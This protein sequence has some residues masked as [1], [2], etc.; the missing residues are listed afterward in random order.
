LSISLLLPFLGGEE[1][2][3]SSLLRNFT[4]HPP[5]PD[6]RSGHDIS[7]SAERA[8]RT[9]GDFSR[10]SFPQIAIK[11]PYV[12]PLKELRGETI[13]FEDFSDRV[14]LRTL[15]PL[16]HTKRYISIRASPCLCLSF[17][18]EGP[19]HL[20][21]G[22][23]TRPYTNSGILAPSLEGALP[24]FSEKTINWLRNLGS[25]L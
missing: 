1:S 14:S 6:Q 12:S 8:G 17:F 18:P 15:R 22:P 13:S 16:I 3:K 9:F 5:P 11:T 19:L 2:W 23:S 7:V 24:L 4:G 20:W 25:F 10:G 21:I